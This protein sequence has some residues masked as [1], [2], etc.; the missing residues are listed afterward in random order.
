M[1]TIWCEDH[2]HGSK[3]SHST[4]KRL[5]CDAGGGQPMPGI[6]PTHHLAMV[7][8]LR[9]AKKRGARRQQVGLPA[10]DPAWQQ[11]ELLQCYSGNLGQSL[12]QRK[13]CLTSSW[14]KLLMHSWS[15]CNGILASW[16]DQESDV[17]AAQCQAWCSNFSLS[18]LHLFPRKLLL[19]RSTIA[20]KM[21]WLVPNS[22]VITKRLSL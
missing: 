12:Q 13:C 17:S 5:C 20:V 22:F 19:L 8:E 6:H 3:C 4:Q 15:C 9:G 7:P 14:E 21:L 11:L 18:R 16:I 1:W 10:F 2:F